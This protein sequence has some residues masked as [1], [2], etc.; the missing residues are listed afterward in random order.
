MRTASRSVEAR[1]GTATGCRR[2]SIGHGGAV[3][4][5]RRRLLACAAI[6]P[7]LVIA[8]WSHPDTSLAAESTGRLQLGAEAQPVPRYTTANSDTYALP[9]GHMLTRVYEYPVNYKAAS[10]QWQPLGESQAAKSEA[11]SKA[12][13]KQSSATVRPNVE[14]NPL[15]QENEA[16]CS[17]TSTAPTTAACNELTFKVGYET[18]TSTARRGLLQFALPE[19]HEEL[20]IYDA[21]L[22]LYAAKTTTT[23]S[24]AMGAY[25]VTTPWSTGAT[26]NTTNGSTPWHTPGGD[27]SNPPE[28]ESDAAINSSVGAKKGWVYWYPTKM[29][30]EWYNGTNAPSG[31]GQADLGFLLKDVSEGPTNNAVSFAGR[32]E[33]EHNPGLTLEWAQR[34]VGNATNYTELP[35]QLSPTL[36]LKV[37]PASGNLLIHSDDLKVPSKG[38]EFDSAR[39]WNSLQNE[40]FGYGYGWVDSNAVNVHVTPTGSVAY[41]DGTG[42]TFPFVKE[43]ANFITPPG[44]EATL[45]EAGSA[46]PCPV[47]LPKGITYQLIYTNTQQRINFAGNK[48]YNYPQEV[49][50]AAGEAETAKY[51]KGLEEPTTWTDTEKVKIAYTESETLGY[52]KITNEGNSHSV[53]YTET[54]GED[55]LPHLVK[56]A[57]ETKE[58]TSYTIGTGLEGNLIKEIT[59]PNGTVIKLSYDSQYRVTKII[60]TTNPEHTTGPTTTYTYYGYGK[61]PAPCT[62]TQKATVVAETGGNEEPTLTYCSNVLDEVEQVSGYPTV[63]QSGGSLTE[64]GEA[65]ESTRASVDLA[66]GNL[67]INGPDVAIENEGEAEVAPIALERV[68]NSQGKKGGKVLSSRWGFG[69]GPSIYLSNY[70]G[71]VVVHG[72][73]GY[74]VPV[75]RVSATAYASPGEFEGTLTKNADGTFTLVN[76][77]GPTYQFGVNGLLLSETVENGETLTVTNTEVNG[78]TVLH[79]LTAAGGTYIEVGYGGSGRVESVKGTAGEAHYGYNAGGQLT[80]YTSALGVKTEYGYNEA[81]Y[82]NKI[83]TPE[84]AETFVIASG[85][86]SEVSDTPVEGPKTVT[87]YTYEGPQAPTCVPSTDTGETVVTTVTEGEESSE[88]YCYNAAGESTGPKNTEAEA[89][90]EEGTE[91][92]PEEPGETCTEDPDLHKEDCALEEGAPEEVEDLPRKDYGLSDNNWLQ[93]YVIEGKTHPSF[94]YLG[95]NLVTA[96]HVKWYRRVIPWDMVT[97][98]EHNE[99]LPKDNEGASDLLADV[100]AWIK[101]VKALG[102]EPVVA[103]EDLCPSATPWANPGKLAPGDTHKCSE[104]PTK[105]QYKEGVER[106]LAHAVLNEVRYFEALNEP[107]NRSI[108]EGERIKPTYSETA[109]AYPNGPNGA[110]LAGEYWRALD[111]LC[112]KSKRAEE[113]KSECFVAAGDFVDSEMNAWNPKKLGYS[114]FHQYVAGMGKAPKAYRWSWH[115]YKDGEEALTVYKNRPKHWWKRFHLFEK[116]VDRVAEKGKYKY[117]NIWLSEQG[118]IYF[119]QETVQRPWRNDERQAPYVM[120]AFVEHGSQ[121][122]TRQLNPV[123]KKGSQIARFFYYSSRGAPDFDS[124]LLEAEVLPKGVKA[125]R[126]KNK[127][128]KI[129]GIFAKK[130]PKK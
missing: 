32:E 64:E 17:L 18:A 84:D 26:W 39:T 94:N 98:A 115:A 78:E 20:T 55:G 129:Y 16:A 70:G 128:R 69:T 91:V 65:S 77:D 7:L 9:N 111:D 48:E 24:A 103:F 104:A 50:N 88:P 40:A 1:W 29:V 36:G 21:Q 12:S 120:R 5:A 80:S 107:D 2:F 106:F 124:G 31:Q 110:H 4:G 114:Y 71:T 97:E 59:E 123:T 119:R 33:R 93:S 96:L 58:T 67:T 116:A 92:P 51:T 27:Y 3:V 100:E 117:P 125:H 44:I 60:K 90:T 23:S 83:T 74:A 10:G 52:T 56:Y 127:P 81:G 46:A 62:A 99:E 75:R 130:T 126:T 53:S 82:L 121:Q 28:A 86:V 38:T 112:A 105:K 102:G 11:A 22:E 15:G 19:L 66:S 79:K 37:N 95:E 109:P 34:G 49:L 61:A 42:A 35:L 57:N 14:R 30:Q 54:V 43:R 113:H 76:E 73:S 41:T 8:L 85:K 108:S 72:R 47:T 63:G 45:C 101:R 87:K 118:V 89:E 25:R 122:L 68:Y 6:A 13:A